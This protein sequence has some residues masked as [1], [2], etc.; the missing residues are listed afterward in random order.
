[1]FAA[2]NPYTD[3][4]CIL[5]CILQNDRDRLSELA[6]NASGEDAMPLQK[7]AS[8]AAKALAEARRKLRNLK[9]SRQRMQKKREVQ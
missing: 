3:S 9:H 7:L 5:L 1:M 6:S 4:L 2:E 8:E